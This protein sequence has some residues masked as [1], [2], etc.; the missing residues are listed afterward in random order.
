VALA[1]IRRVI[2]IPADFIHDF[3]EASAGRPI[4]NGGD[5][6]RVLA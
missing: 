1:E 2:P 3:A 4:Q 6:V 5:D